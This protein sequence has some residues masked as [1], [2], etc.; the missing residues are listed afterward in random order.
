MNA[1]GCL[2]FESAHLDTP[3]TGPEDPSLSFEQAPVIKSHRPPGISTL[4]EW[5]EMKLP[6]GKWKGSTFCR[7]LHQGRQVCSVHGLTHQTGITMGSE[8]S[9]LC[10]SS[11]GGPKRVPGDEEQGGSRDGTE[12]SKHDSV[13]PMEV[14][15]SQH[16]GLGGDLASGPVLKSKDNRNDGIAEAKHGRGRKPQR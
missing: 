13:S 16:S 7:G 6:E 14:L 11:C 5:G 4:R 9:E 1:P 2:T 3:L 12:D 15:T 10:S 8:L